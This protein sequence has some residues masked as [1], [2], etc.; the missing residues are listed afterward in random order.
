MW[1]TDEVP[2]IYLVALCCWREARAESEEGWR[3][4]LHVIRN[5]ALKPSWWGN[6]WVDVVL[7]PYQFSSFNPPWHD[8]KTGEL[9]IDPNAT[10]F[11]V[12]GDQIFRRILELTAKVV[13]GED[14]DLTN[15]ASHYYADSIAK[16][17]WAEKMTQTAKIGRHNFYKEA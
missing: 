1:R 6:G 4:V 5:R 13:V 9:R 3:G 11:P 2:T 10:K 17:D 14:D 16:P 15:G 8:A 7:K 12:V